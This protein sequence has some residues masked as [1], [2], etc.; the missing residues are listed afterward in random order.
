MIYYFSYL[1]RAIILYI[2]SYYIK[3]KSV[4]LI[5]ENE[6]EMNVFFIGKEHKSRCCPNGMF[7]SDNSNRISRTSIYDGKRQCL[8]G[9]NEVKYHETTDFVKY[10]FVKNSEYKLKKLT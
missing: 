7:C 3:N 10:N 1:T 6:F 2:L 9:S 8:D 5:F 4:H